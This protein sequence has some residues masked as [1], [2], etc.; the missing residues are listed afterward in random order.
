MLADQQQQLEDIRDQL[1]IMANKK[2]VT[3]V[4]CSV[5]GKIYKYQKGKNNHVKREHPNIRLS[6]ELALRS[7]VDASTAQ[8]SNTN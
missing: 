2:V 1:V 7:E 4:S 5:C 3:T 6:E 8:E